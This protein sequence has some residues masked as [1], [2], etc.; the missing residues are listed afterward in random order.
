[1]P[2]RNASYGE[3]NGDILLDDVVC[4]GNEENL[5]ECVH[6]P[7]FTTNCIHSEDAG[8]NCLGVFVNVLYMCEWCS[9]V[10]S[11]CSHMCEW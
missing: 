4:S 2:T 10:L 6:N 9:G 1:M 5:L 11:V 8:V 3:G 7:L